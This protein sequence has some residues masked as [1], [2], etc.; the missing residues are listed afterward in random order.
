MLEAFFLS[1][2]PVRI[3]QLSS[4]QQTEMRDKHSLRRGLTAG[5]HCLLHL[6]KVAGGRGGGWSESHGLKE[7]HILAG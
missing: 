4:Y 7:Q 1:L 2:V 5:V 3:L 6:L